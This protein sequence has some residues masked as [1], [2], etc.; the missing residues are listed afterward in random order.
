LFDLGLALQ[1]EGVSPERIVEAFVRYMREDGVRI[2][3]AMF[4]QNLA[5]KK[6]DR[7]FT[8]DMTPLLANA[9][10]WNFDEAFGLVWRE[11]VGRLPGEPWKGA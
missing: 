1:R 9:Q 10:A 7:V 11:L 3:R 5:A 4:E 8:A 6:T 2:T